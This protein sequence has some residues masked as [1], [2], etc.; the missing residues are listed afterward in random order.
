M[1]AVFILVLLTTTSVQD[2]GLLEKLIPEFEHLYMCR[3]KTIAVG[4][5]AALRIASEG[6]GDV[7]IIH[8]QHG[9]EEFINSGFGTK[10]YPFMWN[11]FILCGPCGDPAGV[12]GAKDIFDAFGRI[13]KK[14]MPFVSRGDESGTHKKEIEIWRK[15][16]I[17]PGK[18]W[19]I[20]SGNGMIETLRIAE[21]K[22][23]YVLT[24]ISTFISHRKEFTKISCLFKDTRNLKNVYS[25][26]P[27]SKDKFPWANYELAMKFINFVLNGKGKDIIRTYPEKSNPFFNVISY[28]NNN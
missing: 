25:L 26:I 24:D 5:G 18:P 3:V 14:R 1:S 21:E 22:N 27:V 7:L 16:G 28:E 11:E 15:A 23:C 19:Y 2:S 13:Y 6:N 9:E 4:S 20:K 17:S 10:R 8:D 12:A